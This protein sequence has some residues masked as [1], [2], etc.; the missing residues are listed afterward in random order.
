MCVHE[1]DLNVCFLVVVMLKWFVDTE[2]VTGAIG[3]QR[4]L[5]E[6]EDVEVLQNKTTSL[7]G[8]G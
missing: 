8:P 2:V 5:L 7:C 3:H 4:R 1:L 6:E